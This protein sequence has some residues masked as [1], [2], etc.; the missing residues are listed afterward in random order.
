MSADEIFEKAKDAAAAATGPDE[1]ALQID[2]PALKEKIRAALGDRKVALCHINKFLP[3]GYEEQGRFNLVLL[4]A[5]N[6][7]FDMVIGDQYFR[8]DVVSVS[9]LDKVQLIDAMWENREKRREEPFLSL[10]LMH[11]EET[12]L[13]LALDDAERKS[14]LSFASAVAAARNPEK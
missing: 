1:K 2:Y 3:E 7:V 10:R 8:Y 14:V 5:G 4:T 12:H 9:Q 11:A 6:V 13:L